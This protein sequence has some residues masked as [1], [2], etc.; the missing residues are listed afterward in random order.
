MEYHFLWELCS[1]DSLISQ[2]ISEAWVEA[3]WGLVLKVGR[4]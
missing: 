3:Y 1:W 4:E 2:P